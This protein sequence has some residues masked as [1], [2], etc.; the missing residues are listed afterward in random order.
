M[1]FPAMV[2]WTGLFGGV[3]WGVIGYVAYFFNFTEISPQV[4]IEPWTLGEWKNGW[5]GKV[6]SI[7]IIGAISVGAA[8]VYYLTLRKLKGM[9]FGLGYGIALFLV[10]F[11]ILNPIFPGIKPF[12]ELSRDTIITSICLYMLY[13]IF[14]GYSINYEFEL[15]K[16]QVKEASS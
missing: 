6:I 2:F 10:V 14:I 12:F 4:I 9:W 7:F 1:S 13:G 15:N 8:F 5:L 11:L 16:V 3:F